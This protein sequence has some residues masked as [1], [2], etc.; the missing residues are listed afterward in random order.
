[1]PAATV[2]KYSGPIHEVP[3]DI[4]FGDFNGDDLQDELMVYH[5][6][7]SWNVSLGGT[8]T[9]EN[10]L[11]GWGSAN[12]VGGKN[13]V[14]DLNGDGMDDIITHNNTGWNGTWGRN[15]GPDNTIILGRHDRDLTNAT[16]IVL[17]DVSHTFGIGDIN[18]DG[19]DEVASY[20]YP[21]WCKSN[22]Y[23]DIS[24]PEEIQIRFG[25][26]NGPRA[27]PDQTIPMDHDIKTSGDEVIYC[28]AADIGD[29]NGDG[30]DDLIA[31]Y[32]RAQDYRWN[33]LTN[34]ARLHIYY[35][36]SNGLPRKPDV[37]ERMHSEF[38]E[39]TSYL[40]DILHG[41][42]NKDGYSD[43]ILNSWSYDNRTLYCE[44]RYARPRASTL[45]PTPSDEVMVR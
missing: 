42:F 18:G 28:M 16:F 20:P 19:Y 14:L 22:C 10:W 3:D 1:M 5:Y 27:E 39:N 9:T 11:Y 35:G 32:R 41:D 37:N 23:P 13:L 43:V 2:F 45:N 31:V 6:N 40:F 33:H 15:R 38:I 34:E 36:S 21:T 8:Q 7:V 17:Q 24:D 4:L 30:F 25:G 26:P 29:V 12:V 44:V